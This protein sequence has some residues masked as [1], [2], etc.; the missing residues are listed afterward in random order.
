LKVRYTWKISLCVSGSEIIPNIGPF[1]HLIMLCR[2]GTETKCTSHKTT[3][4]LHRFYA[5]NFE[6]VFAG[7]GTTMLL[8]RFYAEKFESIFAG[9]GVVHLFLCTKCRKHCSMSDSCSNRGPTR[10]EESLG[11]HSDEV[12]FFP[13]WKRNQQRKTG[14]TS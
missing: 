10:Q 6:Y 2:I 9:W 4:L 8:H 11:L 12:V 3:M 7:W 13:C 14:K 1:V 5:E